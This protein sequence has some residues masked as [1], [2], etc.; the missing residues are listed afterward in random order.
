[1][2]RRI[3]INSKYSL[4]G[5]V[6]II[7]SE[8]ES[9]L[10]IIIQY[11]LLIL[12][13]NHLYKNTA[14]YSFLLIFKDWSSTYNNDSLQNLFLMYSLLISRTYFEIQVDENSGS[15]NEF[16]MLIKNNYNQ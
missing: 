4:N 15:Q 10:S 7:Q 5:L 9:S 11:L 13:I 3:V 1:M 16:S 8:S 2:V 14:S 12:L 6:F